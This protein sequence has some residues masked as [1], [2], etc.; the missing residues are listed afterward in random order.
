[1]SLSLFEELTGD[2]VHHTSPTPYLSCPLVSDNMLPA[3]HPPVAIAAGRYAQVAPR[4]L[5][6]MLYAARLAR[7]DL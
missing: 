2:F 4:V 5:M 1:M 7:P 3:D 6:K